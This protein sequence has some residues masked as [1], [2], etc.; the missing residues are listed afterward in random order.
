[1]QVAIHRTISAN[2]E[3]IQ[4]A[5]AAKMPTAV[6]ESWIAPLKI[7]VVDSNLDIVAQNQFSADFISRTYMN[8]LES[9]AKDFG[10]NLHFGTGRAAQSVNI[11]ANDNKIENFQPVITSAKQTTTPTGFDSFIVSDENAF[12]VSAAKKLASGTASFSPLFIYG[13]TGCGKSMLA[14]C[15]HSS[16]HGRALMMTGP[17]FVSEFLRS[18]NEKSVFAFKD[19][20]RNCDVFIMDDVQILAGKRACMDEFLSLLLDLSNSGVGIVLTS[21]AAPSSLTGFDRRM[22]SVFAS[23]LT[24]D[25]VAPNKTVRRTMLLRSGLPMHIAESLS[26]RA[27]ADGHLVAGIAKKI[28]AYSDLM[29]EKITDEIAE[30][31]M[32]DTLSKNKTPLAMVRAMCEKLGVSFDAVSSPARCRAVVRARGIMS[33]ALKSATKL[34]LSEIGRLMGDRDHATI[35]YGIKQI[36]AARKTDLILN[37]EIQQMINECK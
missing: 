16:A 1:M 24:A 18:I 22:Q 34:S 25:L 21:N 11:N 26:D 15:I 5:I 36:D 30:R 10:L 33:F 7:S 17:Q 9:V 2:A 35:L 37:A 23:G 28:V 14:N 29:G 3:L 4:N 13:T 6:Y 12:A 8:I 27:Q 32:A 31:L 19:F 20:C